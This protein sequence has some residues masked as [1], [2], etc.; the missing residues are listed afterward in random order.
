M[1]LTA[2]TMRKSPE[3]F[4]FVHL[5]DGI[6][7]GLEFHWD[8]L[9]PKP[10]GFVHLSDHISGFAR[11]SEKSSRQSLSASCT[12]RTFISRY[13]NL[14]EE[15]T[16]PEPFGFEPF[17]DGAVCSKED[18]GCGCRQSLSA[19]SPFR[20]SSPLSSSLFLEEGRQSLSASSPFR[21]PVDTIASFST[22]C[23]S[24]SAWEFSYS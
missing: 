10:F 16:S 17:S 19:S 4:G 8:L 9:S 1:N 3:P 21:T 5:S 20:T 7:E 23:K 11:V 24:V 15:F 14:S 12:C 6:P 2:D 13:Q 22:F 18:L